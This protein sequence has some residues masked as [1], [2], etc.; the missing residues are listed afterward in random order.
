MNL[1][2]LFLLLVP[3]IGLV[4]LAIFKPILVLN[5][6]A[7]GGA[8]QLTPD[9][10]Y[11]KLTRQKL[12]VYQPNTAAPI[13]GYPTVVFFYGGSWNRGDR[14]DYKFV[15]AA[16]ASRGVLTFVADYRLYPEVRYP[17]FL[18]DSAQALA[19][20]LENAAQYKGNP[21]RVYVMG[22]SAGAYNAAML[23][24]DARWLQAVK[25]SPAEL[26]GFIGIAGPYNFLPMTN[27][28]TQP[29]FFHPNYPSGSQPIDYVSKTSP[30][31]FLGAAAVDHLVIPERN[32]MLL[33]ERLTA[34]GNPPVL[35]LYDRVNH[36]TIIAS[37]AAPL[38]WMAPVFDDVTNFIQ[39]AP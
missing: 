3:L 18:N 10:A 15:A 20:G 4:F 29:V 36:M 9:V 1:K 19:F 26:A 39:S 14:A 30:R 34:A 21:K 23:A 31:S 25:H 16:L 32:T 17:D 38:R 13:G 5:V 27:P 2:H 28:D 24:F 12:D 6:L 7:V 8:Y 35:K 11:G 33:A 37:F 22:H